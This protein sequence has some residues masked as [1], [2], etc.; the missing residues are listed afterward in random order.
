MSQQQS[1]PPY[2]PS[3]FMPGASDWVSLQMPTPVD[4]T[5]TNSS[6]GDIDKARQTKELI[7]NTLLQSLQMQHVVLLAGSGCSLCAG[8]PSMGDLWNV[9][10]EEPPSEGVVTLATMVRYSLDKKNIESF[11]SQIESYLYFNDSQNLKTFF[12]DAK[13]KILDKCSSFINDDKLDAHQTLLHRL[14]RRR[15]RDQRLRVFTTNYDVCFERAAA[16]IGCVAIDGFS[17]MAPR[18]YDPRYYD[19]DIIRRPRS[20]EDSGNYLEGVFQL[21]KLHGSVNW[22]KSD[23]VTIY[24]K[25]NPDPQRACL[26]YPA[27]GKYQQS[28]NQPYIESISQYLSSI[29]EPNTCLLVVG[30]GFNDDHLSGPLVSAVRSNPH[31][32]VIIVDPFLKENITNTTNVHLKSLSDFLRKGDDVWF[33]N[34]SFMDFANRIPDLKSFTP[35]ER[36]ANA[37]NGVVQQS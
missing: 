7:K 21:Y 4:G 36:L 15:T 1:P 16:N 25:T 27:S 35:A 30:F 20:G 34:E 3:F 2:E 24:E 18:K 28:Y 32:R 9:V 12:E 26:I 17:F 19:Y 14:S 37:I 6:Q 5:P 10:V 33:I 31:L 13:R 23:D 22:E 29:R 8:G 11:L